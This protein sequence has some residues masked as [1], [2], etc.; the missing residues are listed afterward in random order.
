MLD[1]QGQ[2]I[3]GVCPTSWHLPTENEWLELINLFGGK[4]VAGLKLKI[5]NP[6]YWLEPLDIQE[7]LSGFNAIPAG[8]R[9]TE[10]WYMAV[11]DDATYWTTTQW[12]MGGAIMGR[13]VNMIYCYPNVTINYTNSNNQPGSFGL[14]I[15]CI[16]D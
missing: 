4:E 11:G 3:Q 7:P 1:L 6:G 10:G 2:R 9:H 13:N 15:R 16:K 12:Y 8:M 14:S 5:A